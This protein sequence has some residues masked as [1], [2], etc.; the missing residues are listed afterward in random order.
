MFKKQSNNTPYIIAEV[1]QNHQGNLE[2]ALEFIEIFSSK[3]A[4]AIKFQTRNNKF[5]FSKEAY[6]KPYNSENA[7][8][9][10]YG[11]HRELLELKVE[12]LPQLKEHC[13]KY[14]VDFMST[15][16][17][18]PSLKILDELD[19]DI[20]K[21]ASFDLGN[22]PF[23]DK[24][25]AT[26]RP[27]VLSVGGGQSNHIDASVE[28]LLNHHDDIA[29][30]HC[31]SEYPCEFDRLGLSNIKNLIQKYPECTI[32]SSD[33]FNGILSGPVAFMEG[34]RV[35]EK[36]V[37][38]N[39]AWKGTDH[40]FAL[41]PNGFNNFTRDLIRTPLMLNQKPKDELGKEYVFQKLGKSLVAYEDLDSGEELT[42]R[43]LSGIIF[44]E[45]YTPVRDSFKFIGKKLNKSIKK[46]SPIFIE[47]VL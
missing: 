14:N 25:G 39:R 27:V 17:D 42:L 23:I 11:A 13:E 15:P 8:A 24:I 35:F 29:V 34:A 33:H 7:F 30:L 10:S 43:N 46:G 37:T 18:E 44:S 22:L 36:H 38:L 2:T 21:I 5:L 32:G 41:E 1:G 16:F 12:W 31:V 6:E 28:T 4:D 19:V 45:Q 26:K 47:D 9:E 40:S 3:G 20:L